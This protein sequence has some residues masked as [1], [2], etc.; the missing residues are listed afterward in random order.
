MNSPCQHKRPVSTSWRVVE[1]VHSQQWALGTSSSRCGGSGV[2]PER[3]SRQLTSGA[4][5]FV[6][7][8]RIQSAVHS[9]VEHFISTQ[10]T[11]LKV[12]TFKKHLLFWIHGV[13]ADAFICC[14]M[15]SSFLLRQKKMTGHGESE[16]DDYEPSGPRSSDPS[17]LIYLYFKYIYDLRRH[18]F[19][20]VTY[21]GLF[22][23]LFFS[24]FARC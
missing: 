1:P 6:L 13:T 22:F 17:T 19:T 14:L 21:S 8:T 7:F 2:G 15:D 16:T 11:G 20:S 18:I 5:H 3:T 4:N 10:T 24:T 12:I 9:G 23:L